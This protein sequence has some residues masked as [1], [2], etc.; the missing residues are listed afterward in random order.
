MIKENCKLTQYCAFSIITDK[1]PVN[2]VLIYRPPNNDKPNIEELCNLTRNLPRNTILI[3]DFNFPKIDWSG[4][5][6]GGGGGGGAFQAAARDN[7]LEQLI[8]FPTHKKGN[9]LD[10]MLTNMPNNIISVSN[11]PP[12]GKSDHCV[13]LTEVLLPI[14]EKKNKRKIENW[15]KVD[16]KAMANHLG[17]L[18]WEI[19]LQQ[20]DVEPAWQIFKKHIRNTVKLFVPLSTARA[21][22]DPKWL[23]REIV[24][25]TRKKASMENVHET[26]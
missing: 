26:F 7:N 3:G 2:V 11:S 21:P 4:D 9:I 17:Q 22:T 20:N 23:T 1:E 8:H 12:L 19:I 24:K 5:G 13:I 18:N 16:E 14:L 10:L 6:G 15:S 25:L